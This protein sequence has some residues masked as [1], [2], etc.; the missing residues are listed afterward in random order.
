MAIIRMKSSDLNAL[1]NPHRKFSSSEGASAS[2]IEQV[3]PESTL[4]NQALAFLMECRWRSL[5]CS[6]FLAI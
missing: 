6:F 5:Y 4:F 2:T 3:S 1:Q